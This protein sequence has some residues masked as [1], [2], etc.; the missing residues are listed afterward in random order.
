VILELAA[1]LRELLDERDGVLREGE[2]G[3]DAE[4][5]EEFGGVEGAGREDYFLFG[6]HCG[7]GS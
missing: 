3:T 1:D 4:E 2:S 5:D 6:E 7:V